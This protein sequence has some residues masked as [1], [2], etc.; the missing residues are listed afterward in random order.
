M[1]IMAKR[2]FV[3]MMLF[4]VSCEKYDKHTPTEFFKIKEEGPYIHRILET[5]VLSNPPDDTIL[6]KK[7][8]EEYNRQTMPID[9][10][11]KYEHISREFYRETR[12]LTRNYKEGEPYPKPRLLGYPCEHIYNGKKPGQQISYHYSGEGL[13]MLTDY[14]IYSHSP[15]YLHYSYYFGEKAFGDNERSRETTIIISY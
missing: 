10:I 1:I 8:V 5:F 6:L 14:I 15:D 2:L 11:R 4:F 7:M 12:C 9:T 3:F 13:L